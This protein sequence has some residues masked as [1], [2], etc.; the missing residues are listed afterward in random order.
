MVT[1]LKALADPRVARVAPELY[2]LPSVA[3]RVPL[4]GRVALQAVR[5]TVPPTVPPPGTPA[6]MVPPLFLLMRPPRPTVPPPRPESTTPVPEG[7]GFTEVKIPLPPGWPLPTGLQVW[8]IQVYFPGY[9]ALWSSVAGLRRAEVVVDTSHGP[10]L[11]SVLAVHARCDGTFGEFLLSPSLLYERPRILAWAPGGFQ[12]CPGREREIPVPPPLVEPA[13]PQPE[14]IP[15]LPR[16]VPSLP[17]IQTEPE[18]EEEEQEEEEEPLPVPLP[19]PLPALPPPVPEVPVEVPSEKETERR[20]APVPVEVPRIDPRRAPVP[21][22]TPQTQPYPW[23]VTPQS[24]AVVPVTDPLPRPAPPRTLPPTEPS[25]PT[26]RQI[27]PAPTTLVIESVRQVLEKNRRTQLTVEVQSQPETY[28]VSRV[29]VKT[30]E[31][32]EKCCEELECLKIWCQFSQWGADYYEG[33]WEDNGYVAKRRRSTVVLPGPL[34]GIA[35]YLNA[36]LSDLKR[37]LCEAIDLVAFIDQQP[38]PY[39]DRRRH[40]PQWK[41]YWGKNNRTQQSMKV[42]TLP[43]VNRVDLPP[44]PP[45]IHDGRVCLHYGIEAVKF[46]GRI[47]VGRNSAEALESYLRQI[48][49]EGVKFTRSDSPGRQ[50]RQGQLKPIRARYWDGQRWLPPR[51]WSPRYWENG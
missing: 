10:Q 11:Y 16:W 36:R 24:P 30:E 42:L 39:S 31:E 48:Y 15:N 7:E 17:E 45:P 21:A 34:Q 8:Q 44:E 9:G 33:E 32:D 51:R 37:E 12:P 41:I 23:T 18:Q 27:V 46:W 50:Y 14:W 6:R 1:S 2:R 49:G 4:D 22:T 26:R 3:T 47:W 29:R 19:L 25:V 13:R 38:E 40:G 43:E 28:K 20:L 5:P 35:N